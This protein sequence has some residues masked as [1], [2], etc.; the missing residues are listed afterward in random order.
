MCKTGTFIRNS[1]YGFLEKDFY[2]SLCKSFAGN[3]FLLQ[4]PPLA[5]FFTYSKQ[6]NQMKG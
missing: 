5:V 6:R 4:F 1:I 2:S 3:Q